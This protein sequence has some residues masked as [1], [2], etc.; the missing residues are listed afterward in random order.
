LQKNGKVTAMHEPDAPDDRALDRALAALRHG[1]PV[2]SDALVA[3]ILSDAQKRADPVLSRQT[4]VPRRFFPISVGLGIAAAAMGLALGQSWP[5]LV[6]PPS[7]ETSAH[8]MADF[9]T[10]A[11]L[12]VEEADG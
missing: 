1:A 2:P 8:D 6:L 3:R 4:A 10:E 9:G 7:H 5:A 11:D 12:W